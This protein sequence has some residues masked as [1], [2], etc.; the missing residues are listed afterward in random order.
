MS[1][2]LYIGRT[3]G[4]SVSKTSRGVDQEGG[5]GPPWGNGLCSQAIIPQLASLPENLRPL[6]GRGVWFHYHLTAGAS[7]EGRLVHG[8]QNPTDGGRSQGSLWLKSGSL[9]RHGYCPPT[10][11]S[12]KSSIRLNRNASFKSHTHKIT[13]SFKAFLSDKAHKSQKLCH[14]F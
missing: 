4:H 2:I 14:L 9:Q 3:S 5:L 13:F 6:P 7:L 1:F 10:S 11:T 12:R 8:S